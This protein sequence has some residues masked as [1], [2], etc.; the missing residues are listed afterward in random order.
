MSGPDSADPPVQGVLFSTEELGQYG[1]EVAPEPRARVEVAQRQGHTGPQFE[2]FAEIRDAWERE[3][4]QQES[5]FEAPGWTAGERVRPVSGA[6][7]VLDLYAGMGGFSSGFAQA[8]FQVMGVDRLPWTGA[9]FRHWKIGVGIQADL[10]ISSVAVRTPILIGGPPCRPWS[11]MNTRRRSD[12][13]AEQP[14]LARF[15]D[16][17]EGLRPEV[18]LFE[19]VPA[20]WEDPSY[21]D[22]LRRAVRCGYD[23]E[24]M[25]LGYDQF[26]AP[27]ARRRLFTFGIRGTQSG[28]TA[29]FDRLRSK[30]RPGSSVE[31]AI[32][33][34]RGTGRNQLEDHTWPHFRTLAR[35]SERYS[36]GR[37]GW[38]RLDPSRPAPSFGNVMKTYVQHPDS[39]QPGFEPR[40]L[41]VR[42]LLC[43]MGFDRGLYF[44]QEVPRTRR[45][46][47]LAD[48]VSPVAARACAEVI[49]SMVYG[50]T[51]GG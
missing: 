16:H 14:L 18:F 24:A 33:W 20:V 21:R 30:R 9:V 2:A 46:Q 10:M 17:I 35:Y 22:G 27:T 42:E 11:P 3:G 8:G 25:V 13:H 44:P 6:P 36:S 19:N 43:I 5:M 47:M 38:H 49:R 26:G 12:D 23:V 39:G 15:F 45:Y 1:P 48:T 28:A 50:E 7:A 29:F 41:S 40:V 32:G 51:A 4:V 31:C 37:F 34:L